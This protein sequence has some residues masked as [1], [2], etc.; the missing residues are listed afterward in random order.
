[1]SDDTLPPP[2][3]RHICFGRHPRY[4]LAAMLQVLCL[5]FAAHDY[6]Y[7]SS[8]T[9]LRLHAESLLLHDA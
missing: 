9:C 3:C 1:M 6:S 5:F 4:E 7:V 2:P 8:E